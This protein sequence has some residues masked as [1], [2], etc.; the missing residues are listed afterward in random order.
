M[1]LE[2]DLED[3]KIKQRS[4]DEVWRKFV[5]THEE[6]V[7]CLEVIDYSEE[8]EKARQSY[9]EQMAR[10]FEIESCKLERDQGAMPLS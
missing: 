6:Y 7:E 9:E 1:D 8:L 3:L 5:N 10:K 2:G 4:D